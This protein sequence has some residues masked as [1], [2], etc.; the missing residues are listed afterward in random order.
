MEINMSP[1][2][3]PSRDKYEINESSYKKVVHDAL[4]CVIGIENEER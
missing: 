3:T 4:Q 1:N 2:L